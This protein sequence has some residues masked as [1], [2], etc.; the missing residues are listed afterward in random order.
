MRIFLV[1]NSAKLLYHLRVFSVVILLLSNWYLINSYRTNP[2]FKHYQ[3]KYYVPGIKLAFGIETNKVLAHKELTVCWRRQMYFKCHCS[4]NLV[5][6]GPQ[7]FA[8]GWYFSRLGTE[9]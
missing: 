3:K 4:A 5:W 8:Q 6:G 7:G 2:T 9:G 1:K